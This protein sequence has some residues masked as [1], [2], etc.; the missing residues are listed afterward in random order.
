MGKIIEILLRCFRSF[1]SRLDSKTAL[2]YSLGKEKP[3]FLDG[4]K[5]DV[6]DDGN[7]NVQDVK[8]IMNEEESE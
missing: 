6:N 3:S 8:I 5:Y 1:F 4:I 7:I 2:D